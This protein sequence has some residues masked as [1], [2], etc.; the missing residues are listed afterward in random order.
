M[1]V[2]MEK[3]FKSLF[4]KDKREDYL[5]RYNRYI[6]RIGH[7]DNTKEKIDKIKSI[8]LVIIE[9]LNFDEAIQTIETNH[10]AQD[11]S[12]IKQIYDVLIDENKS[13]M[14]EN[15]GKTYSY[16]REY[17]DMN[18]CYQIKEIRVEINELP[19]LLNP[20]NPERV[21]SS[22]ND[23]NEQNVF[24]GDKYNYNIVNCY[25]YP[26]DIVICNG[27][28]HSQF[29]ARIKHQ[30]YTYIRDICDYS[31]L[32]DYIYFDGEAFKRISDKSILNLNFDEKLIFYS[33]IIF[34]Y[35][36]ILLE[37]GYRRFQK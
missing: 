2:V 22:L 25:L 4:K 5:N 24:D 8:L 12:T 21:I 1:T 13:I 27:G 11:N 29:S 19:I 31:R 20:W 3:F 33:G 6:N 32:Y 9:Y 18:D 28:N 34:E 16:N 35:G 15:S 17:C 30:G 36:R 14:D 23:I 26:M 10:E 7:N 37:S